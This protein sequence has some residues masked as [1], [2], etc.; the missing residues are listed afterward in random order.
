MALTGDA[1]SCIRDDRRRLLRPSVIPD[2]AISL[3]DVPHAPGLPL[4][5][6]LLRLHLASLEFNNVV[7]KKEMFLPL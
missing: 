1:A 5:R 7:K 2:D 4:F 3:F 6:Y